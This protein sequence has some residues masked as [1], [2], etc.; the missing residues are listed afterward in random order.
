MRQGPEIWIRG[1]V[2]APEPLPT[3]A[4]ADAPP[5][6]G[7]PPELGAPPAPGM[8]PVP[9]TPPA[10]A[11]A[12]G[13]SWIGAHGGAGVSTLAGVYG[14]RDCGQSWPGPGDPPSVLL[15]A[16]THAAGLTAAGRA[17]EEFRLGRAPAGVRLDS[18]VLVAD[19]PG[20][21]PR[22]LAQRVRLLESAVDVH[23]VPWVPAWRLD[24]TQDGPP[25]GTE[26]LVSRVRQVR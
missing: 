19:A 1:P 21:L 20:R 12:P 16:R 9:G 14:G 15:V 3:P 24:G 22:P 18:V 6:P 2:A 23:R 8:P 26:S 17:V 25:R 11:P 10:P 5:E 4:A 13:F 7:A